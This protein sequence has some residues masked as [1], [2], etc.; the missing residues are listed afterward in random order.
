MN[1]KWHM[2]SRGPIPLYR[3]DFFEELRKASLAHNK[4]FFCENLFTCEKEITYWAWSR[5]GVAEWSEILLKKLL[6]SESREVHY[7]EYEN[8]FAR[9]IRAS[10]KV[11]KEN[12]KKKSNP[13]LFELFEYLQKE[14]AMASG[15]PNID[16][17]VFDICFED[18][19]KTK[20]Q[21][22]LVLNKFETTQQEQAMIMRELSNSAY[23][24]F[25]IQEEMAIAQAVLEK[26]TSKRE[27][28]KIYNSF[29]WVPLGWENMAP[30]KMTYYQEK[31]QQR[32]D[33]KKMRKFVAEVEK[34]S[35]ENMQKRKEIL[36]KYEFGKEI[37]ELLEIID[38]F[39]YFHDLR[40]ETQMR[41][42][43]AFNLLSLEI[44]KRCH[45]KKNERELLSRNETKALLDGKQIE[46]V[47]IAKRKKATLVLVEKKGI[48]LLFG[49][50]AIIRRE[51]EITQENE[52]MDHFKGV[53]AMKGK[54]TARVKVCNGL[55]DA[56]VKLKRGEI[57]VVGMTTPDY[58]SVMKIAGAVI[59]SEGGITCHAAIVS[60]ELGIPCI[61][62]TKIAT[63]V[64][65]DGDLV[66]VD[67]GN[68]VVQILE[69][70]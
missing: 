61:V 62:G 29:W 17:D 64:L 10:E 46:K 53:V 70:K 65:H 32:N 9:S 34:R 44:A 6:N 68:G 40:K 14:T 12:L 33:S 23:M 36:M 28:E 67:A 51:K 60:R 19:F 16:L 56:R 41:A 35:L 3:L 52:K 22:Q 2:Y 63:Q 11:K 5:D 26:K 31:I 18:F 4:K 27:L 42:M 21:Q 37:E 54:V 48:S 13:E 38:K 47:E 24:T 59:T 15:M 30:R 20:L 25:V 8:L 69:R 58:V 1:Q 50:E 43:F 57:L 66:E 39:I 45:F 7:Q 55:Q 49:E